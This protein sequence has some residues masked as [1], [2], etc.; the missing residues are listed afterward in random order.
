MT[1]MHFEELWEKCEGLHKASNSDISTEALMESLI[2]K[3]KLYKIIDSKTELSEEDRKNAKS[4]T[5]GEILMTLTHVS[6]RDNINVFEALGVA[7]QYSTVN[8]YQ[9]KIKILP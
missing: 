3:I 7:L 1:N 9:Q 5:L 6:L 8:S 4:R 2:M